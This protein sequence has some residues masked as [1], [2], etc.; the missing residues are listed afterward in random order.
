MQ[1]SDTEMDKE[2]QKEELQMENQI[3]WKERKA[4]PARG[5]F[6][7]EFIVLRENNVEASNVV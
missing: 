5:T 3:G 2:Q 4:W 7:E 6:R 1:V